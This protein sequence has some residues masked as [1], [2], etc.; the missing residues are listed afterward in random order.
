MIGVIP[1]IEKSSGGSYQYNLTLLEALTGYLKEYRY[2]VLRNAE[3]PKTP[4]TVDID[5]GTGTGW[6]LKIIMLIY[7]HTGIK[8]A[9]FKKTF[10]I[11]QYD[12]DID[13]I[14]SP[15]VSLIPKCLDKP[16]L[17]T[18]HDL[19]HKY[20]PEFFSFKDRIVREYMYKISARH[21]KLIIC[22]TEQV[23]KDIRR[24]LKIPEAKIRVIPFPPPFYIRNFSTDK[25]ISIKIKKKYG[26]PDKFLFYP[27]QFWY[28]K[29]HL[30]LLRA[31]GY[32]KKKFHEDIPLVLVGSKKNSYESV[33]REAEKL[34]IKDNINYL[35]YVPEKDIPYLYKFSYALVMPSLFEGLS[36]PVWEAFFLGT[37]VVA[38]NACSTPEQV[39]DAGLLFNPYDI[40]DIADKIHQI[41]SS[42]QLR[43]SLIEKGYKRIKKL[44]IQNYANR[45]KA[46]IKEVL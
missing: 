44:T 34:N 35:G 39:E 32:L 24:Y 15:V 43:N 23:K 27:A 37:P 36:I 14:V 13:F 16:Y 30:N 46:I 10:K 5:L 8:L 20:Y 6:L 9:D 18:I 42:M 2:L 33:M 40:K 21:A 22:S 41:W 45:L 31:L 7:I 28:H 17:L 11:E 12:K 26:L 1:F 4:S 19:Q 3:F 38:S 29:N 25:K